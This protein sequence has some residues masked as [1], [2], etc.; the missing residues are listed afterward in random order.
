MGNTT[1]MTATAHNTSCLRRP[2]RSESRP[3]NGSAMK[4]RICAQNVAM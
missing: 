3:Q 4:A 2:I 1:T